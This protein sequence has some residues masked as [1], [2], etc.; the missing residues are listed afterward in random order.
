MPDTLFK[1]KTFTPLDEHKKRYLKAD[2]QKPR[3]SK[4]KI[5]YSIYLKQIMSSHCPPLD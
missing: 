3:N 5:Q 2:S 4:T 1:H